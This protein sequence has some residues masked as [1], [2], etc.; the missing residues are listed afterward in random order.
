[1]R[2]FAALPALILA[3]IACPAA[4]GP[5]PLQPA[6]DAAVK[7]VTPAVVSIWYGTPP[8]HISGTVIAPDGLIVTCGHLKRA[9]GEAVE[10]HFAG[11]KKVGGKV[12]AK[13]KDHDLALIQI[14]GTAAWP[15]VPLSA[16]GG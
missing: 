7:K 14:V 2:S 4:D 12:L 13:H 1:M 9:A 10:V 8:R 3:A 16:A 5:A 6:V 15:T 11:G